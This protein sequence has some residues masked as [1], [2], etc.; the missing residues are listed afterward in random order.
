LS[1]SEPVNGS[2]AFVSVMLGSVLFDGY[3]RTTT[4]QDL[5]AR[6]ERPYIVD[7]PTLGE[8]LVT[9]LSLGGLLGAVL[10]AVLQVRP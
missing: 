2:V 8:L 4:W 7:H 9:L 10:L 3:S 1:G 5:A 6:V